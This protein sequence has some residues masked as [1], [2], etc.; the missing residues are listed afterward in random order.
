MDIIRRIQEVLTCEAEAIKAG[1]G[2]DL[3][4]AD[5]VIA[6]ADQQDKEDIKSPDEVISEADEM[7]ESGPGGPSPDGENVEVERES[8]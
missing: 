2:T 4:S 5:E 7:T 6:E 8:E 1:A 3:K